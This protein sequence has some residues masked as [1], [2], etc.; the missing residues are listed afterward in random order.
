MTVALNVLAKLPATKGAAVSEFDE[1]DVD[2]RLIADMLADGSED[3]VKNG[4]ILTKRF[5]YPIM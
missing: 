4:E 5:S 3:P 2:D 1:S